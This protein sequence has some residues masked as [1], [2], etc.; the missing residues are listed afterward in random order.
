MLSGREKEYSSRR[1]ND[2]VAGGK[3]CESWEKLEEDENTQVKYQTIEKKI[4]RK[5]ARED[6][7]DA[8]RI[9]DKSVVEGSNERGSGA[10]KPRESRRDKCEARIPGEINA[11]RAASYGEREGGSCAKRGCQGPSGDARRGKR[12]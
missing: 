4:E 6:K 5:N 3:K 9:E 7:K 10:V 11:Q 12:D 1:N 2:D 8:R